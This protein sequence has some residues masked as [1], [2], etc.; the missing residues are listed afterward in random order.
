MRLEYKGIHLQVMDGEIEMT[1]EGK[2]PGSSG[3][4]VLCPE[5]GCAKKPRLETL[6]YLLGVARNEALSQSVLQ[7]QAAVG[8]VPD[9]GVGLTPLKS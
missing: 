9:P 1:V 5:G 6:L 3:S 2:E 4:V 7:N 8:P